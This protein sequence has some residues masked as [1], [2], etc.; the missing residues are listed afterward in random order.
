MEEMFSQLMK[1]LGI[2]QD[3]EGEKLTYFGDIHALRNDCGFGI[4]PFVRSKAKDRSPSSRGKTFMQSMISIHRKLTLI[5]AL[6]MIVTAHAVAQSDPPITNEYRVTN[7]TS[8]PINDKF[9]LFTYYGYTK[10]PE[11]EY[12]SIY[13]SPPNVIYIPKRWLEIYGAFITVYTKNKNASHSWEFR[14]IVGVKLYVPNE[15]KLYIYSWTRFEDRLI[16]QD[17]NTQSTPRL[18]NRFGIEAPLAKGDKK[19]APKTFYILTDIEP[20]FRLDQKRLDIL[21]IRGGIGYVFSKKYRA[22][23]QYLGDLS[24]PKDAPLS[25]V[26][27][28]WRLNIKISFPK[29]GF[30]YPQDVDID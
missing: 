21:R 27:N 10:S 9:V 24:T 4:R 13:G 26:N 30:T 3:C 14:P 20:I 7:T 23:F 6:L 22:E 2:G 1:N 29:K 25:H 18:R 11:K 19:W 8:K 28:I 17:G 15:K 16:R 5:I 12:T